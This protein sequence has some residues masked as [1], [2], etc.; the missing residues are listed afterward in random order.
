M[1]CA[2]GKSNRLKVVGN[3]VLRWIFGPKMGKF[4]ET[5]ENCCVAEMIIARQV[6][7]GRRRWAEHVARMGLARCFRNK[8]YN[9]VQMRESRY[10]P[11]VA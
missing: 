10:R 4:R 7:S 1:V 11:G 5:V 6:E 8:L 3:R 9:H 2:L